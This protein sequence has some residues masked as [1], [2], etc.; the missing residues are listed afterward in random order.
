MTCPRCGR[1][2]KEKKIRQRRDGSVVIQAKHIDG[3]PSHT[4]S[5]CSSID[6]FLYRKY[7]S[8]AKRRNRK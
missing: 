1:E 8:D 7:P 6:A 5:E 3:S 2:C 4:Y